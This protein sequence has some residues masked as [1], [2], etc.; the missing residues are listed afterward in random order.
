MSFFELIMHRERSTDLFSN[1]KFP[2]YKIE[3]KNSAID[4]PP[5]LPQQRQYKQLILTNSKDIYFPTNTT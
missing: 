4:T 2:I 5:P 1:L 3:K